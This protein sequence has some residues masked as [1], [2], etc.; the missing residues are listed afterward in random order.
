MSTNFNNINKTENS[1]NTKFV[2]SVV[3]ALRILECFS[4]KQPELSLSEISKMLSIPKS[5]T[6]NLIRTLVAKGYLIPCP[7]GVTYRLG[8]KLMPLSYRL[9]ASLPVVHYATPFLEE[10]QVKTGEN[11][12][13]TTHMYGQVLYLE[14]LYPSIRVGNYSIAG[15]QLPMHCTGCGKAMLAYLPEEEIQ[16]IIDTY[17]LCSFTSKT[18]TD[19]DELSVELKKIRDNGYAMDNGE[20]TAGCKCVALPIRDQDGYPVGSISISG[21]PTSLKDSLIDDYL[22]SMGRVVSVL[23]SMADQFPAAQLRRLKLLDK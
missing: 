5:T 22:K 18:I 2:N 15:K 4:V 17:G 6:L 19:P 13:L 10:L 21:T 14:G 23:M 12:Y 1:T 11:V 9:R 20:E 3:K 16:E 7:N 8:Y